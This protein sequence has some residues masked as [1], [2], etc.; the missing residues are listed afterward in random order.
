LHVLHY[1]A[2]V[3]SCATLPIPATTVSEE[4]RHL[5]GILINAASQPVAWADYQDDSA[6]LRAL[7]E[8]KLNDRRPEA[9]ASE[10]MP[11]LLHVVDA[12]K[13][14]VALAL[15]QQQGAAADTTVRKGL[16]V[17]KA[18]KGKK[19]VPRRSA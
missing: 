1:P 16:K 2:Q 11:S 15:K 14:S 7:I 4:E 17:A 9:P 8:A 19:K 3:R 12:L 10:E 18:L 13:Q 6:P 5:A